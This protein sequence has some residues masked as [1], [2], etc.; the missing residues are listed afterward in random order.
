M[1]IVYQINLGINASNSHFI[2]SKIRTAWIV[3][4][5]LMLPAFM[6]FPSGIFLYWIPGS[7]LTILFNKLIQNRLIEKYNKETLN[8]M[9]SVYTDNKSVNSIENII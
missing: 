6:S 1:L 3:Y 4:F 7:I 8:Y 5:T 2:S 9:Q